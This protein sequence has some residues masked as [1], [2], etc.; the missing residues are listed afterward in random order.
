MSV[1]IQNTIFMR[2]TCRR[3]GRIMRFITYTNLCQRCWTNGLLR[4]YHATKKGLK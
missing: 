2:V 4:R 1:L 3:C